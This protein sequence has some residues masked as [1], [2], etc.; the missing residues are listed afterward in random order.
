MRRHLWQVAYRQCICACAL[1]LAILIATGAIA[2][3]GNTAPYAV[4][5][6]YA[7]GA[8]ASRGAEV[9]LDIEVTNLHAQKNDK[10][11]AAIVLDFSETHV[12]PLDSG[13]LP[14]DWQGVLEKQGVVTFTAGHGVSALS[15][16]T[17]VRLAPRV[18]LPVDTTDVI[19]P[20]VFVVPLKFMQSFQGPALKAL[21]GGRYR[22]VKPVANLRMTQ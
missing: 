1:C 5:I 9:V 16:G 14:P 18:L 12:M 10:W 17:S 21:K 22:E 15:R 13:P 2:A 19:P 4:T 11:I 6:T 7:S 8:M 20:R 3:S